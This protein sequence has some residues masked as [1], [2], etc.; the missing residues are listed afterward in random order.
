MEIN[1]KEITKKEEL[2]DL[3]K[4]GIN[5]L[6]YIKKE[7][8]IDFISE[9]LMIEGNDE[10]SYYEESAEIIF[11]AIIYYIL[12]TENEEKTL[13]RCK[14]IAKIGIDDIEGSVKLQNILDKEP[15]SKSLYV[16]MNIASEKNKK[17]IFDKLNERLLKI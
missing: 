11:K 1:S 13:E 7:K 2:L 17:A 16:F 10:D 4:M 6:E 15:H 3:I 12:G 14:E 5:P 9:S 8:D